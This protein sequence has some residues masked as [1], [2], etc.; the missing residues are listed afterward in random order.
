V[1]QSYQ[2]EGTLERVGWPVKV[3]R[4]QWGHFSSKLTL[5]L[6]LIKP[7]DHGL[8]PA[9]RT[10]C[11]VLDR[12]IKAQI[13]GRVVRSISLWHPVSCPYQH[14]MTCSSL[15]PPRTCL[16]P[17]TRTDLCSSDHRSGAHNLGAARMWAWAASH[18]LSQLSTVKQEMGQENRQLCAACLAVCWLCPDLAQLTHAPT[19]LGPPCPPPLAR[20][21]AGPPRV[22]SG[23]HLL[24]TAAAAQ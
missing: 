5:T 23:S 13:D 2:G 21:A 16:N 22:G 6:S 7:N 9:I 4:G 12:T 10:F 19:L 24:P 17:S 14:S 8:A 20:L 1:R 15:S 3:G 11:F 18:T